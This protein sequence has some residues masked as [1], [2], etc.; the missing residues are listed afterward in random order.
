MRACHISFRDFTIFHINNYFFKIFIY[1]K[2]KNIPIVFKNTS[3]CLFSFFH[4]PIFI[5]SFFLC[6]IF[7][8]VDYFPSLNSTK[9]H[10]GFIIVQKTTLTP[11]FLLTLIPKNLDHQSAYIMTLIRPNS[12][13]IVSIIVESSLYACFSLLSIFFEFNLFSFFSS[14]FSLWL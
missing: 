1:K 11:S 6:L 12:T 10:T 5:L 13:T 8:E 7:L 9:T 4:S 3:L 14:P 2:K